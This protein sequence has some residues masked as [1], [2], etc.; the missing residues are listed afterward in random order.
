MNT[1]TYEPKYIP[2]SWKPRLIAGG[3]GLCTLYLVANQGRYVIL[4][5]Y[6][7]WAHSLASLNDPINDFLVMFFHA[8]LVG[9]FIG[10]AIIA[11]RSA[12]TGYAPTGGI[13]T[14]RDFLARFLARTSGDVKV[15][16]ES[17]PT[18]VALV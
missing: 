6:Q 9:G 13:I 7:I 8:W 18:S 12:I 2:I 3:E 1:E 11:L 5:L 16:E 15:T 17:S 10:W 14:Y 4:T